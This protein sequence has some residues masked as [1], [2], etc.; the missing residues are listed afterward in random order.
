MPSLP[1]LPV[2]NR[3]CSDAAL[4]ALDA[5]N[6]LMQI[7]LP[8]RLSLLKD[9][10]CCRG[11]PNLYRPGAAS[12][13]IYSGTKFVFEEETSRFFPGLTLALPLRGRLA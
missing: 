7:R 6:T 11:F 10:V 13:Y 1:A 2:H 12:R 8:W 3:Y 9:V 4:A 5:S